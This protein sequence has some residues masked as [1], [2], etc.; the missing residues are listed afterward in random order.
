MAFLPLLYAVSR[1]SHKLRNDRK[2]VDIF[3]RQYQG[4]A[5]HVLF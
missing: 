3:G 1:L 2:R 4:S 5:R